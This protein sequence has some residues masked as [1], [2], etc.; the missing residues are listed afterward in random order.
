MTPGGIVYKR[1][2]YHTLLKRLEEPR[3]FIQVLAGP[4]QVGKTTIARQVLEAVSIP[5]HFVTADE[6]TLR[7]RTWL[8]QQWEIARLKINEKNK[9]QGAVLILDETQKVAGWSEIIKRLWDEDARLGLP[10][11]VVL[12]GSSPLLVQKG[13]TESLAG[14]FELIPV[15]HWS[16]AEMRDAFGWDVE[17]YLVYGG[18]PGA[19]GLVDD[20]ERWARY[21]SDSIIETTVSRDILLLTRVDKPALLRRLFQLCCDYS[22]Q[23]LSYQKMLGQLHDAGNTTTLSH[24][25]DLL[26]GAGLIAGLAK[27]SGKHVKQRASSPKIQVLNTALMSAAAHLS[28]EGAQED[29]DYWGR[30]VETAVG[31]HLVNSTRGKNIEVFYWLERNQEVDFVISAGKTVVAMEVK[32][33]RRRERL[34]G[35]E[36]FAKA[37]PVKRQLLVGEEGIP[38]GEFLST[39]I[40][41]WLR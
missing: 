9:K 27:F 23:V 34:V 41:H 7:D 18:Y 21:I 4:R 14:R 2:V 31:A 38:V 17:H 16:Y 33:S 13:L 29:R 19:A 24:Y 5:A 22:G 37:F 39:P 6:P 25:L 8:T 30:L 32:S 10:L 3:R 15:T 1:A 20:H 12:L 26:N 11:K 40:E 35:M 28:F 36:A